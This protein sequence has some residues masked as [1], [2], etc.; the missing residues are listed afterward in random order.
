MQADDQSLLKLLH[1]TYRSKKIIGCRT[2]TPKKKPMKNP[3]FLLETSAGNHYSAGI[4]D[5]LEYLFPDPEFN[6]AIKEKELIRQKKREDDINRKLAIKID[7]PEDYHS[8][9]GNAEIL[10]YKKPWGGYKRPEESEREWFYDK[11]KN[12]LVQI[13]IV[14]DI[15]HNSCRSYNI[16]TYSYLV[17]SV[18]MHV[19]K[20]CPIRPKKDKFQDWYVKNGQRERIKDESYSKNDPDFWYLEE[21]KMFKITPQSMRHIRGENFWTLDNELEYLYDPY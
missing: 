12:F 20:L 21:Q 15:M 4:W 9:A 7:I 16:I 5:V 14:G 6:Q 11:K 19:I 2:T 13:P 18:E 10:F 8:A 17:V 1:M 3:I